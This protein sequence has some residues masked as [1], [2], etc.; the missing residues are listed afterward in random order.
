MTR[1]GFIGQGRKGGQLAVWD[2]R[3]LWEHVD[4]FPVVQVA[5]NEIQGFDSAETWY[6]EG[7]DSPTCRSVAMHAKRIMNCS[8]KHPV[9]LGSDNFVLD[10]MHRIAKAWLLGMTSVL[11]VRLDD[12]LPPDLVVCVRNGFDPNDVMR[13]I[14]E[15]RRSC[16]T[17]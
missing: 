9:I 6:A 7:V 16:S 12:S 14:I 1:E 15:R 13:Q 11:A 2:V 4:G 10:G 17:A 3:R 8:L 5:I